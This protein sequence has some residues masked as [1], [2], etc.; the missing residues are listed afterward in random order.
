M[1]CDYRSGDRESKA[2]TVR[3]G[4]LGCESFEQ[5][6]DTLAVLGR[7]AW[8]EVLYRQTHDA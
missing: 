5:V 4:A 6:E 7:D 3:R 8:S 1:T 2:K